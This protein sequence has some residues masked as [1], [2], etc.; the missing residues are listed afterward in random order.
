MGFRREAGTEGLVAACEALRESWLLV[1]W[2]LEPHVSVPGLGLLPLCCSS[3]LLSPFWFQM[4]SLDVGLSAQHQA[5][6]I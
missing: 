2:P 4:C 5:L 1:D 3:S 6:R